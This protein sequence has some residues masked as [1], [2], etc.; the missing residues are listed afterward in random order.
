LSLAIGP[1]T[2]AL[3]HFEWH[4]F[5]MIIAIKIKT[6]TFDLSNTHQPWRAQTFYFIRNL[7]ISLMLTGSWY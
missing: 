1:C 2:G 6:I 7:D 4:F 5:Y 3:F